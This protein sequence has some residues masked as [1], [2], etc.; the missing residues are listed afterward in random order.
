MVFRQSAPPEANP[1]AAEAAAT[2]KKRDLRPLRR[3]TPY[4]WPYRGQIA[5]AV[6]ALA[7]ASA[8]VLGFGRGLKA[9]VD[10]GFAL[11]N[12]QLLDQAL[13]VMLG[14]I[15]LLAVS[16]YGRFYLVSFVGER[17]VADLRRALFAHVLTLSPAYFESRPIGDVISRLT[18][19]TTMLQTVVGSSISVALRNVLLFTGG[20]AMMLWTS[21]KL[22]LYAVAVVPLVVVP[23]II[24]GRQVRQLSRQ[25]QARIGDIGSLIDE[26]LTGIRTVQAFTHETAE[27]ARFNGVVED[28]FTTAIRRVTARARLSVIVIVLAFGSVGF[29][30]WAGGP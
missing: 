3:L 8:T 22:T 27:T 17:V 14:A 1:V 18:T 29:I 2:K 9:V 15:L 23:I 13:L 28:T 5:G 30:L 4:L 25:T 24:F 7:V 12:P 10:Q 21:P 20:L 11:G 19:D 26:A 16:T 6:V